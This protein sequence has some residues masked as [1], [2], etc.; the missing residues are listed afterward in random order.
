MAQGLRGRRLQILRVRNTAASTH[1]HMIILFRA[2]YLTIFRTY[3]LRARYTHEAS[4][5][6]DMPKA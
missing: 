1:F 3:G 2:D 4:A 5:C 6:H